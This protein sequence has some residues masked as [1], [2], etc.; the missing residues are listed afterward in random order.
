MQCLRISIE[1]VRSSGLV[2][3]RLIYEK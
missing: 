3:K 1:L 2:A